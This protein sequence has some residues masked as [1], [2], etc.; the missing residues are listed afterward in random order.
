MARNYN[1]L[2]VPTVQL[3]AED[4]LA[5][6]DHGARQARQAG[7][8]VGRIT[9]TPAPDS[10]KESELVRQSAGAADDVFDRTRRMANGKDQRFQIGGPL[11]RGFS[12]LCHKLRGA[13]RRQSASIGGSS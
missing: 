5:A 9:D 3:R 2:L 12:R 11:S 8:R 6:S 7:S 1:R 4:P 13:H 10:G